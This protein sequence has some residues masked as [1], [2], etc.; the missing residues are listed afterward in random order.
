[1]NSPSTFLFMLIFKHLPVF[2]WW[3]IIHCKIRALVTPDFSPSLG[4]NGNF[5]FLDLLWATRPDKAKLMKSSTVQ[6]VLFQWMFGDMGG[7]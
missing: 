6:S 3:G 7:G 1:M 4:C 2:W 5:P